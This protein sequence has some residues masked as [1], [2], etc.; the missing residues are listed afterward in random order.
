MD[1]LSAGRVRRLFQLAREDER[2]TELSMQHADMEEQFSRIVQALPEEEQD[3]LW[4]FV[5]TSEALNW[6]M[7]DILSRK[8]GWDG[9]AKRH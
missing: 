2:Y 9:C 1:Q 7:L 4:A 8:L 3:I 6:C 5:C